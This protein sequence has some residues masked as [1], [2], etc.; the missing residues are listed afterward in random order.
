M[1]KSTG[2]PPTDER[3]HQVNGLPCERRITGRRCPNG[4]ALQAYRLDELDQTLLLRERRI[5][6]LEVELRTDDGLRIKLEQ[7]I[8]TLRLANERLVISSVEAQ[9]LAD[10]IRSAKD[11]MGHMAHHDLLTDLPNR[12]LLL[13]RLMQAIAHARRHGKQLAVLF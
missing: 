12:G 11:L 4:T 3:R 9:R 8:I 7:N 6:A 10:E 13:E 5:T 1:N 2:R